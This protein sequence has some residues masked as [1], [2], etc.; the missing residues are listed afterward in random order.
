MDDDVTATGSGGHRRLDDAPTLGGRLQHS[1]S[2]GPA[3]IA[4]GAARAMQPFEQPLEDRRCE[5]SI[6]VQWRDRRGQDALYEFH[7]VYS[8]LGA[9][10]DSVS[11]GRI[12]RT[13][14]IEST[15]ALAKMAKMP[16]SGS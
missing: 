16:K 12:I 10:P 4:A 15:A 13:K 7:L 5:P 14:T 8:G 3:N 6:L 9:D 2:G 1:F 11:R